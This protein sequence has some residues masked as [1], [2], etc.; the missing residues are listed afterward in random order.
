MPE[1]FDIDEDITHQRKVWKIER[2]AWMLMAAAIVASLCGFTGHGPLSERVLAAADSGL[3]VEYQRFERNHAQSQLSLVLTG[4]AGTETRI[5]VGAEFLRRNEITRIEPVPARA[6]LGTDA[7]TYVFDT[8]GAGR[9]VVHFRPAAVGSLQIVL[10][11][12]DAPPLRLA[13]FVYP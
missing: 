6:E 5:H 4:M 11:R 12:D 7:T 9:I 8:N 1:A 3:V 13:Q 2:A 10:G